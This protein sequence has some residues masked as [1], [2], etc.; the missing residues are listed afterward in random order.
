MPYTRWT[1]SRDRR[2]RWWWTVGYVILASAGL[3][4]AEAPL[5]QI[6]RYWHWA[7][8]VG[9]LIAIVTEWLPWLYASLA[10][11][12]AALV[13]LATFVGYQAA[14]WS[15]WDDTPPMYRAGLV[16]Y[17]LL[18]AWAP[19]FLAGRL[20]DLWTYPRIKPSDRPAVVPKP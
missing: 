7:L 20:V 14:I 16:G 19:W 18:F 10:Q 9:A 6:N 13:M 17:G 8:V 11:F 4:L 2:W 15:V 12:A 1:R 3:A 5:Q